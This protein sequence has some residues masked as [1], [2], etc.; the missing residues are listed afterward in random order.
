MSYQDKYLK[1]K[2]KYLQLK[3]SQMGGAAA[4]GGG[5][6]GAASGGGGSGDTSH[7][8]KA[9]PAAWRNIL[10]MVDGREAAA[11]RASSHALKTAVDARA[12]ERPFIYKPRGKVE[13]IPIKGLYHPELIA[14]GPNNVVYFT[15]MSSEFSVIKTISNDKDLA[16]LTGPGGIIYA[17]LDDDTHASGMAIGPNGVIYI[18]DSMGRVI[19]M[20][21]K[22]GEIK[23]IHSFKGICGIAVGP[24]NVIYVAD[25]S[26]HIIRMISSNGIETILAGMAGMSGAL[27]GRGTEARFNSPCG[28]AVGPDGSVYVA[29]SNNHTIRIIRNGGDVV[30]LAGGFN[31]PQGIAVGLDGTVYVTDTNNNT[32]RAISSGGIVTTIAGMA[33]RLGGNVD[34]FGEEARF[35][36]PKGIAIS[37]NGVIYVTDTGNNLIRKIT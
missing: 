34:G 16:I 17:T 19:K 6:G 7:L 8:V 12:A 14:V 30:T 25:K 1:Y 10:S 23:Y 4:G 11:L 29:D 27:D 15:D 21:S 31:N 22:G 2:N 33:T 5:G 24:D 18:S 3:Y 9:L 13:T 35:S 37:P 36:R 20:I 28:V 32:I 26:K